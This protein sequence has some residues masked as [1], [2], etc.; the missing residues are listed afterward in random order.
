MP[1]LKRRTIFISHAWNY[2][3][4]YWTLVNWFDDEPNFSWANCSVPNHDGLPDK[5][6]KGLSEGMTRQIAAAQIIIVV[7]GM[8]AAHRDWIDYEIIEAQRMRKTILG[9]I[10]WGQQRVPERVQSAAHQMVRW[11]SASVIN[12]IRDLV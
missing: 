9:V 12:A 7:A 1:E 6:S 11:N 8:Y 5:T 10:P 3:A 2:D 4:D